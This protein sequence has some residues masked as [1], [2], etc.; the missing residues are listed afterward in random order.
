MQMKINQ[1]IVIGLTVLCLESIALAETIALWH[2]DEGVVSNNASTLSSEYNP[3]IMQATAGTNAGGPLPF[4]DDDIGLNSLVEEAG[5]TSIS[6]NSRS[7][8]FTNTGL[9]A[10]LNS[11]KGGVL[12]IPHNAIMVLSK[13]TAEAVVKMD[14]LVNFPLIIGKVRSGGTT[15][16][17]DMNNAGYPR[18]RIDSNPVGTSSGSG[19]NQSVNSSVGI[20]DGKW[21]HVAFTYTHATRK[22]VIYVDYVERGNM[23]TWSNLVYTANEMRIGQGAGYRY[24]LLVHPIP[25]RLFDDGGA[26]MR[27]GGRAHGFLLRLLSDVWSGMSSGL[28]VHGLRR[29][30]RVL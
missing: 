1:I 23:T 18:L 20:N 15:W 26:E 17:I 30:L 29:R 5:S 12:T 4:F 14:R 10:D 27:D 3:S 16:N 21:H 22:A 11:P 9:P 2:F 24:L 8:K 25:G 6:T 28:A 7:L 13:L 19:F